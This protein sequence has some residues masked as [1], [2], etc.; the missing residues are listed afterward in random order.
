MNDSTLAARL[1]DESPDAL[2]A[3]AASG[4]VLPWNRGASVK[5]LTSQEQERLRPLVSSFVLEG[6]ADGAALLHELRRFVG[7]GRERAAHVR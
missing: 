6:S 1:V 2:L 3:L 7:A 5:E 4:R